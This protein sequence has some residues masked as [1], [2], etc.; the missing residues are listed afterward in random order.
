[1]NDKSEKLISKSG[2]MNEICKIAK[3]NLS[4][5]RDLIASFQTS[6]YLISDIFNHQFF[7]DKLFKTFTIT[8]EIKIKRF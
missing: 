8:S 5:K 6:I 2:I 4:L 1:M 3:E 7:K